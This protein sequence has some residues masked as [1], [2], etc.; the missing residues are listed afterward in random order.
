MYVVAV[1]KIL[2]LVKMTNLTLCPWGSK[3][4]KTANLAKT[5]QCFIEKMSM[6]QRQAVFQV[7]QCMHQWTQ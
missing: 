6:N 1:V 2:S 7:Y 5:E 3:S 4:K